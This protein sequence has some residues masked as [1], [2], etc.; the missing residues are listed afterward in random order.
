[1]IKRSAK[2]C[3][4]LLIL[5]IGCKGGNVNVDRVSIFYMNSSRETI[6]AVSCDNFD[7]GSARDSL[8]TTTLNTE[9]QIRMFVKSLEEYHSPPLVKVI[10]VRAKAYIYYSTGKVSTACIDQ[11]GDL[12][13]DGKYLGASKQLLEFIEENCKGF[14]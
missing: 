8:M 13:L 2:F 10:D 9:S 1:M 6:V 12:K 14:K 3:K 7:Q 5:C 4:Y 11:F